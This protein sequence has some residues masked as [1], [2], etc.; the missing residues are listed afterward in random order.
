MKC[1]RKKHGIIME[2]ATRTQPQSI[3]ERKRIL[4][5]AH[6]AITK[7]REVD[8]KI[9]KIGIRI[10]EGNHS[11]HSSDSFIRSLMNES[12]CRHS[13]EALKDYIKLQI[14]ENPDSVYSIL[15]PNEL[16]LF[17]ERAIWFHKKLKSR[18]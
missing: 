15:K 18:Y 9:D 12:R 16:G 10:G 14:E 7:Q 6:K 17:A 3:Q 13:T 11:R 8:K 1:S 5:A 2:Y 4:Q